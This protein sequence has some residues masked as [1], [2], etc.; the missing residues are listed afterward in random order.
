M[1]VKNRVRCMI[2]ISLLLTCLFSFALAYSQVEQTERF[3]IVQRYVDEDFTIIPL[4][5]DGIALFRKKFKIGSSNRTWE[6]ILLDST[7]TSKKT[8]ELMTE[9]QSELIAYEHSH[10]FVHFLFAK[11]DSNGEMEVVSINLQ[12]LDSKSITITTELKIQLTHFNKC[13]DNFILGGKVGEE[14]AVLIHMPSTNNIK[15][16][17]GFFKKR[18]E[19]VDVRVNENQTFNTVLISRENRDNN[20]IVFRT[21]DSFGKQLLED[22]I[23]FDD[24]NLQTGISSNLK[25]D[26]LMILGTWGETGAAQSLGF[27]GVSVNPFADQKIQFSFLGKLE[28]YL[29]Y[30]KPKR[31][32]RI[33]AKTERALEQG[34]EPDFANYILPHSIIEYEKG[35]ILLA[36]TYI[37]SKDNGY[38]TRNTDPYNRGYN[39][40]N[41]SYYSPYMPYYP[42][43]G[44]Y[45]IN[46]ARFY[47]NNVN[48]Q[49][50]I[51]TM[52]SQVIFFDPEG[53]VVSDYSIDLDGVKMP[54]LNQV[55]D[56]YLR[57]NDLYFLYKNESEL[58]IKKINLRTKEITE[59]IQEVKMSDPEDVIRSESKDG[60]IRHWYGNTFYM[61]GYQTVKFD[62][63]KTKDIFYINRVK[64]N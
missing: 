58:I 2:H 4:K 53:N 55:T 62:E 21:F 16:I 44:V 8:M 12:S 6:L 32:A 36:E 47:A 23:D 54:T 14:S 5:E 13:G 31:A 37:P 24:R 64:I 34:R 19:L 49:E 1:T 7:V 18:T 52:Q 48:N 46:D 20:K 28:H 15:I 57:K 25:R 45:N 50:E 40:Y 22:D 35:F 29:D 38:N 51:K 26:D 27:Y 17:P 39:A 61:Y 3:E 63:G 42:G 60:R 9:N 33:R 41:N 43:S 11:N 56:F 10:G 30:L 59:S